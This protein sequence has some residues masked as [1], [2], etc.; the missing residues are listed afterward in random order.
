MHLNF[1]N[2]FLTTY[3][4]FNNNEARVTAEKL[5]KIYFHLRDKIMSFRKLKRIYFQQI[6]LQRFS[7]SSFK[8]FNLPDNGI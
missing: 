6:S 8:I 5:E 3:K 4:L 2:I 1:H 7:H